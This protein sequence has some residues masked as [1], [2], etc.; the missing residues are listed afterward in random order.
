MK[1]VKL[2][3][4]LVVV[5]GFSSCGT[6]TK[7]V[8]YTVSKEIHLTMQDFEYLGE[9]EVS[10]QYDKYLFGL[11]KKVHTVNDEV[12][13]PGNEVKLMLPIENLHFPD[14]AMNLAAAKLLKQYPDAVYF[15]VVMQTRSKD[16]LFLG[17]TNQLTARV[18][19]YKFK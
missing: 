18:R 1:L 3:M 4:L 8:P 11:I 15:Q 10:C 16:R 7:S 19:A 13:V 5:V 17:S 12:F 9:C 2:L 6:V 14:K